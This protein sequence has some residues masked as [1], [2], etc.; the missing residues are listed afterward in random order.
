MCLRLVLIA[1]LGQSHL[2][3][4]LHPV[5]DVFEGLLVCDVVHQDDALTRGGQGDR[6]QGHSERFRMNTKRQRCQADYPV[7]LF[8]RHPVLTMAPLQQA[9]VM[10]LNLSCPAVSLHKAHMCEKTKKKRKKCCFV[11]HKCSQKRGQVK[12]VVCCGRLPVS[13]YITV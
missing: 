5:L 13:R 10:V 7:C 9:V 2:F 3:D 8:C 11:I 4:A 6:T 12:N 1:D